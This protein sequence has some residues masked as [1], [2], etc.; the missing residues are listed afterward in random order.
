MRASRPSGKRPYTI[1]GIPYVIGPGAAQ[2]ITGVVLPAE[3]DTFCVADPAVK[4]EVAAAVASTTQ[5]PAPVGLKVPEVAVALT[6]AVRLYG[7]PKPVN[8]A[9]HAGP[10]PVQ[11][12]IAEKFHVVGRNTRKRI[13]DGMGVVRSVSIPDPIN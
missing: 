9:F 1:S 11:L 4:F 7:S 12:R 8:P 6:S 13:V 3:I 5:A 10:S 2:V